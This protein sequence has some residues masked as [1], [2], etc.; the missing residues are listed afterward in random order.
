MFLSDDESWEKIVRNKVQA[1]DDLGV[2][3]WLN[4]E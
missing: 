1:V 3:Y 4:T 2:K